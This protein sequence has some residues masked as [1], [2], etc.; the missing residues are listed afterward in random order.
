MGEFEDQY[1][2]ELEGD[3]KATRGA[4]LAD[5]I[6]VLSPAEPICLKETATVHE[7]V[8]TMLARRQAGDSMSVAGYRTVPLVDAERRPIGVVTVS[9]VIRW[10]AN[11]FPEAVLNLPPG[12]RIKRPHEIDAG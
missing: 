10:L 12:D 4:L 3:V 6:T 7:A 11:L 1:T 8:Q 9:D 5:T 2:Q